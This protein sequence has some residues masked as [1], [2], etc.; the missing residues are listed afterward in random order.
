MSDLDVIWKR[1]E[2][3]A[4]A[5][6]PAGMVSLYVRIEVEHIK[7]GHEGDAQ[8]CGYCL[9]AIPPCSQWDLS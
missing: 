3:E 7:A 9:M 4:R 2:V 6:A 5:G 1:A 8:D